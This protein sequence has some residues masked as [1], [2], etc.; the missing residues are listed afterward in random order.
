MQSLHHS[1]K[2]MFGDRLGATRA[3]LDQSKQLANYSLEKLD[4]DPPVGSRVSKS[5]N[6]RSSDDLIKVIKL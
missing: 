1:K 5:T 2:I 6:A 4:G 3:P